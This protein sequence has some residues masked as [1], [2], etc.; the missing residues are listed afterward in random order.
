MP[1][2]KPLPD[3]LEAAGGL[4]HEVRSTMKSFLI[5]LAIVKSCTGS[6][7]INPPPSPSWH[8]SMVSR[9]RFPRAGG[10]RCVRRTTGSSSRSL[11]GRSGAARDRGL[12]AG[13]RTESLEDYR[14]RIDSNARQHGR[15]S[16]KLASNR[17]I[18]NA[19][20]ERLETVWEFHPDSGGFWHEVT[21]RIIANRQRSLAADSITRSSTPWKR[22]GSMSSHHSPQE[23]R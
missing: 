8:P 18:N 1:R 23:P 11:P 13:T 12:R 10:W 22:N 21:V 16:G 2:L 17:V 4:R 19:R 9:R 14:T 15:P 5:L 3:H 7:A 20:G 6:R